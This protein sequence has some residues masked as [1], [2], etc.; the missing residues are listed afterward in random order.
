[1]PLYL[2]IAWIN[3]P[4]ALFMKIYASFFFCSF[5]SSIPGSFLPFLLFPIYSL[6]LSLPFQALCKIFALWASI[7]SKSKLLCLEPLILL[8]FSNNFLLSFLT[9]SNRIFVDYFTYGPLLSSNSL[10]YL[11]FKVKKWQDFSDWKALI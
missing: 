5:K 8:C 3:R 7:L 11:F 2:F 1:M 10:I 9:Y 4:F 6:A